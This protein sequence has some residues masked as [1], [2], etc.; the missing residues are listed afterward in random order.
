M[1]VHIYAV[2]GIIGGVCGGLLILWGAGIVIT[3]IL[4]RRWHYYRHK[5]VTNITHYTH[6]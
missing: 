3:Q 4:H 1:H 5:G 2:G 6:L